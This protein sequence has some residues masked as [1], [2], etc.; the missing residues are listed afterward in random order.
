MLQNDWMARHKGSNP[1]GTACLIHCLIY[2]LAIGAIYAGSV[3]TAANSPQR[4]ILFSLFVFVTHW[5]IDGWKLAERWGLLLRQSQGPP[6]RTVVD[7]TM[8]IIVLAVAS[9]L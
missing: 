9:N 6:V 1:A 3:P 7:Q 5:A 4:L 2:T 8:H